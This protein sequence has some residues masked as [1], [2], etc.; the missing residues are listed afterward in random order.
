MTSKEEQLFRQKVESLAASL[1]SSPVI[2]PRINRLK[3]MGDLE[4][5]IAGL[6]P[7]DVPHDLKETDL[8]MSPYKGRLITML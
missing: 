8:A 1:G 6:D 7:Q 2:T 4:D 3:S 5:F